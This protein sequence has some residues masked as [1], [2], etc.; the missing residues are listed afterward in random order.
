MRNITLVRAVDVVVGAEIC[1]ERSVE[2][3][4]R[5]ATGLESAKITQMDQLMARI[6]RPGRHDRRD[7]GARAGM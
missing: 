3:V 7:H 5:L 6:D 1:A 4:D 2:H